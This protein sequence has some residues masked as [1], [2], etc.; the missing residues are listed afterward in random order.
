MQNSAS[1]ELV[2][3]YELTFAGDQDV[4][5]PASAFASLADRERLRTWALGVD[6]ASMH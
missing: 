4:W 5:I 3:E 2:L 1:Q 6:A